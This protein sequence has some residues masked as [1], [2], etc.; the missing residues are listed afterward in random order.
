MSMEALP[1][2]DAAPSPRHL[3]LVG[4]GEQH[5]IQLSIVLVSI[6]KEASKITELV[7]V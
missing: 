7:N 5:V 4:Q 6:V 2:W 3:L 1:S